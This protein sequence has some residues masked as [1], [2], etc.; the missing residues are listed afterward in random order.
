[1]LHNTITRP[2]MKQ[3]V[4]PWLSQMEEGRHRAMALSNGGGRLKRA[5]FFPAFP[6]LTASTAYDKHQA[7]GLPR[8]R[9]KFRSRKYRQKN[10]R[11]SQYGHRENKADW[12]K[13][14]TASEQ[15]KEYRYG[16]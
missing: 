7:S 3:P 8:E 15:G 14:E 9:S 11:N 6:A 13:E 2:K 12:S 1:M 10:I 16:P 5:R 4:A